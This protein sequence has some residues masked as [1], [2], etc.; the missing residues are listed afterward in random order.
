[1]VPAGK[2]T[3]EQDL[4]QWLEEVARRRVRPRTHEIYESIVRLH[5]VPGLGRKRLDR[6]TAAD[7]RVC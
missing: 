1:M 6:L 5:L 2:L 3:V 7:V 4:H